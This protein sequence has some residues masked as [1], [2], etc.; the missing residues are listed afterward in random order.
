MHGAR[1]H[2]DHRRQGLGSAMNRVGLEWGRERGAVVAGLLTEAS[3]EAAIGQVSGMGYRQVAQWLFATRSIEDDGPDP[4]ADGLDLEGAPQPLNAA[5][6]V[7]TEP[8][9][10]TWASSELA[11]AGHGLIPEGWSLRRMSVEDVAAAARSGALF[12]APSGW[13]IVE[14]DDRRAWIP[15]L[16]TIADDAFSLVRSV[17][18][19]MAAEG[20]AEVGGLLPHVPWLE[21]ALT[22]AGYSVH[23]QLV[24]QIEIE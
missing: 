15:W 20:H 7:D 21:S 11:T 22:R 10:L 9:Y 3:N 18:A 5:P 24:W 4:A 12:E 2:P 1:V 16:V 13:V 8:A 23:P 6:P 17:T 14:R 19:R